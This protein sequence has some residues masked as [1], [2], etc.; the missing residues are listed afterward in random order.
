MGESAESRSA[1]RDW[2][3]VA[4]ELVAIYAKALARR[5]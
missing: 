2:P 4:N 1:A 3:H 5:R